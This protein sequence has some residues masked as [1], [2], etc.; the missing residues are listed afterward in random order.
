MFVY[1][2]YNTAKETSEN[3]LLKY[4]KQMQF[5]NDLLIEMVYEIVLY[6]YDTYTNIS[7]NIA[8]NNVRLK[9]TNE[10]TSL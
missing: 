6:T 7:G 4:N 2:K 3:N 10:H 1:V 8:N 9:W 5:L